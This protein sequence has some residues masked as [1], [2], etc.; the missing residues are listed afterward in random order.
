[1]ASIAELIEQIRTAIYGR[2]VRESIADAIEQ[3]YTDMETNIEETV[4]EWLDDHP[5]AT[6]TVQDGS[7]T[8][9]K[10]TDAL[11]LKT[12]KEYVT[13]QMY[14]A[15]GDG[16]TDDTN[17]LQSALGSGKDI[18]IPDG[19]YMISSGLTINRTCRIEMSSKAILK[20]SD[21]F[22][23]FL[24][25]STTADYDDYTDIS[26]L[27][28]YMIKGG[29]IDC[30]SLVANGIYSYSSYYTCIEDVRIKNF[31]DNGIKITSTVNNGQNF[32]NRCL[33]W[34]VP[35]NADCGFLD[36]GYDNY[37]TG[38]CAVNC[39]VGFQT[40]NDKLSDCSVWVDE[41]G[42]YAGSVAFYDKSYSSY[43]GC[44]ADTV[45]IC[46]KLA[47]NC[48]TMVTNAYVIN[49]NNVATPDASTYIFYGE[50]G[51]SRVWYDHLL[52]LLQAFTF[53]NTTFEVYGS[54]LKDGYGNGIGT[55]KN[56]PV[57]NPVIYRQYPISITTGNT[58]SFSI[59]GARNREQIAIRVASNNATDVGTITINVNATTCAPAGNASVDGPLGVSSILYSTT[60]NTTTYTINLSNSNHYAYAYLDM[61]YEINA[62]SLSP[63]PLSSGTA[64][65]INQLFPSKLS[66]N[67]KSTTIGNYKDT[68]TLFGWFEANAAGTNTA[69]WGLLEVYSV[70]VGSDTVIF[71]RATVS[72]N[73]V[74]TRV[75]TDSGSTWGGWT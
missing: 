1:M 21:T 25:L 60:N 64:V 69:G 27:K 66:S 49:N 32:V 29:T 74:K 58:V 19:T 56:D 9:A 13:P 61:P 37:F 38:C 70:V 20:A 39:D 2:D 22:D 33:A 12:L 26:G 51:N 65:T 4:D 14:G 48:T 8:E 11:K 16:A 42:T 6:T 50:S 46:W 7:L 52:V 47:A 34:G 28:K 10:F 71:Q 15:K 30:D 45:Q 31:T 35:G 53:T 68:R 43:V 57:V 23:T 36:T 72:G 40:N 62:V 63:T 59:T 67:I 3:C 41:H 18:Y 5:E 44:T 17:A 73:A 55:H 75:S 54:G 24:T